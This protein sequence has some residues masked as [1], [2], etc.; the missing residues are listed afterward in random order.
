M[1][2]DTIDD[3]LRSRRAANALKTAAQHSQDAAVDRLLETYDRMFADF[4]GKVL[5]G[6][7]CAEKSDPLH[8]ATEIHREA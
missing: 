6:A 2:D 3:K 8:R 7:A 4:S 1:Y 5:Q